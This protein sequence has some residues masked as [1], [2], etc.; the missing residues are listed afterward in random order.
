MFENIF[1]VVFALFRYSA[2]G[3]LHFLSET[4]EITRFQK[5]INAFS[6]QAALLQTGGTVQVLVASKSGVKM[7]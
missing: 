4:P 3:S 6:K 7:S 5:D 1:A 2:A